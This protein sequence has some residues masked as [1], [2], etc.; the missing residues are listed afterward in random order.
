M[1]KNCWRVE[2]GHLS[3]DCSVTTV[4][5]KSLS[6]ALSLSLFLRERAPNVRPLLV[7]PFRCKFVNCQHKVLVANNYTLVYLLENKKKK[8]TKD[9]VHVIHTP[10]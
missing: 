4:D 7:F 5:L 6:R 9:V 8:D 3:E 2:G 1:L 10:N